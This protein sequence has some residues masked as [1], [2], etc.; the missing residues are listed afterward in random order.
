MLEKDAECVE[1]ARFPSCVEVYFRLAAH[2]P[3]GKRLDVFLVNA[4][5][6]GWTAEQ[7]GSGGGEVF[8]KFS[9]GGYLGAA[10]L[11]LDRYYRPDRPHCD[12]LSLLHPCADH[13]FVQWKGGIIG[14]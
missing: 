10:G 6:N 4:Q 9:K 11:W 5:R 2:P 7:H 12:P 8:V 13:F 14:G 3:L 1:G